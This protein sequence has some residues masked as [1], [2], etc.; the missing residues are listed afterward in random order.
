MVDAETPLAIRTA[1]HAADRSCK[2]NKRLGRSLDGDEAP[3]PAV[4]IS[5]MERI[6]SRISH[7][8]S[9]VVM[10]RL[11]NEV[12]PGRDVRLI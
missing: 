1:R 3:Q 11:G 12:S 5:T 10:P 2:K 4:K 8:R 9:L 7:H 6:R